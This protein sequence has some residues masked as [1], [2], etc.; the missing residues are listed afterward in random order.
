MDGAALIA[1]QREQRSPEILA[2]L[3]GQACFT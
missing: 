1:H 2:R 3:A